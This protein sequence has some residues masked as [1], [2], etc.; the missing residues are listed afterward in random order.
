MTSTREAWDPV[1]RV[2]HRF[3]PRGDDLIIH[4]SIEPGGGLVAHF[5]PRQTETW[6]VLDGRVR[7]RLGDEE[8][9]VGPEDGDLVVPPDTTHALANE[10]E[11]TAELR[12]LAVPALRL[13]AFLEEASAAGREGLFTAAGLPRGLRGVRWAARFLKRYRDETVFVSPP[14][15]VQSVMIALLARRH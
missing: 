14:A 7:F 9:T 6:T 13:Q 1:S 15:V 12:C 10:G 2:R 5:H 4:S 3:E 11:R 8:R